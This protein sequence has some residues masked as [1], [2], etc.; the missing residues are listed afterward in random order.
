MSN[1]KFKVVN[2]V[3]NEEVIIE[4]KKDVVDFIVSANVTDN[5]VKTI[6]KK[7]GQAIHSDDT[8][9]K[10]FKIEEYFEDQ[11]G[12]EYQLEKE[13]KGS[14]TSFGD[15]AYDNNNK[16]ELQMTNNEV[17]NEENILEGMEET[18]EDTIP[19]V[20]SENKTNEIED[21][22]SAD[23]IPENEPEKPKEEKPN[24]RRIG[25]GIIGYK[26]GEEFERF[27]SIKAC[28]TYMKELLNLGHMPFT[29]IMK[30]VRQNIDWNEYS[31]KHENEADLHIP[32][33]LKSKM[34]EQAEKETQKSAPEN[35]EP[36]EQQNAPQDTPQDEVIEEIVEEII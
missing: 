31:F 27:P 8:L 4:T 9:Y 7:V 13:I 19:E 29:P 23:T 20:E 35:E 21:A 5:S 3:T 14:H 36:N 26:N 33:S 6:N 32:E 28:A 25:K 16:E 1:L 18:I 2:V 34:K 11:D 12:E 24:K 10:T 15:D 30:S 22:P 17:K